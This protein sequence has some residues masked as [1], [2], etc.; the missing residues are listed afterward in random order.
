MTQAAPAKPRGP[1]WKTWLPKVVLTIAGLAAA[2][3]IF[4]A[5]AG[6]LGSFEQGVKLAFSLPTGWMIAIVASAIVA[7]GVYPLTAIAA[8]PHVGYKAAFIDRQGGFTISTGIPFGGGPL[9]VATQYGVLAKY[10]IEQ[11]LAAAA[12]AADAV[13]TYLMT[14][15]APAIGLILLFVVE[16]RSLS[17][18]ECGP[19]S[20]EVIDLVCV[21]TGLICL[22]SVVG[23]AF[24]LRSK[25]NARKVGEFAQGVI[26][27]VFHYIKRT[28]PNVVESVVGF[29]DSASDMVGNRWKSLTVANVA[30]QLTPLL[31]IYCALW[32]TGAGSVS[33]IEA[34]TA[35]SIA[36]VATTVPIAPGGL[37]TV[38]AVLI[39]M[40]VAFG[41][42]GDQAV[43]V[44]VIWR[45]FCF[46]PQMLVGALAL[47]Y[48]FIDRRIET[49]RAARSAA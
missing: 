21:V 10:G 43:A 45:A 30:A 4:V 23:I 7:I 32:G 3:F 12:V 44:D 14:F 13:W 38:D 15:G 48:F 16:R 17:S 37:G 33:I 36:L 42:T 31:V 26:G 22:V 28:P 11:R 40:L 49:R 47:V 29:N 34:F 25:T 20:C 5:L 1:W 24:V 18:D 9:A 6:R 41:A 46:F 35:Y 8:I 27:K 2:Y 39:G 19:V